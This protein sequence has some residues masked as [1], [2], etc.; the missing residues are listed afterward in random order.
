MYNQKPLLGTLPNYA[1]PLTP[2]VGAWLFNENSGNKVFDLSGNG[3]HGTF[4]AGTAAPT[5]VLGRTGSALE[6]D[7]T[8]DYVNI[9]S[10]SDFDLATGTISFW[11]KK[12]TADTE[13]IFSVIQ[14]PN[15]D[16]FHIVLT[17][18]PTGKINVEIEDGNVKKTTL[19]TD[20]L[21]IL[22]T[23][24]HHIVVTQNGTEMSI[25]IDGVKST[26]TGTN[27]DYFLDHLTAWSVDIGRAREALYYDGIINDVMIYNRA[28]S[29]SEIRQ[30]YID[31]YCWLTQPMEAEL[32]YAAPPVGVMS[33]YYYE[34][35]MAGE[36]I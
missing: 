36:V 4:G 17:G 32:M 19:Y 24:W 28:L 31:P 12:K 27:S 30:L 15:T 11:T 35:L 16:Y 9:P 22:D 29:A 6:F 21:R 25:Y 26:V 33:P 1:H 34:S 23:N 2:N 20:S 5:W 18:A 10:S 3:N 14:L 13:Y 8:E 7:G